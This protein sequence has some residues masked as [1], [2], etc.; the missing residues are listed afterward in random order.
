MLNFWP[1]KDSPD[2]VVFTS[3]DVID[4]GEWIHH[5]SHDLDDGA[6]QFHSIN[7]SP[8]DPSDARVVSL[9][10]IVDMDHSLLEIADLPVGWIASRKAKDASWV[11]TKA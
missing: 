1:F 8:D 9:K 5:V 7:G 10:N 3:R 4:L 2:V 11:R 6:W